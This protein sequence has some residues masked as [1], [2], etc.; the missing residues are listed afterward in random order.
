[1]ERGK[2][3]EIK[4]LSGKEE[5]K[6]EWVYRRVYTLFA[7]DFFATYNQEKC[8][9]FSFIPEADILPFDNV[10]RILEGYEKAYSDLRD[11]LNSIGKHRRHSGRDPISFLVNYPYKP[12]TF[13]IM[14]SNHKSKVI[15]YRALSETSINSLK[16]EPAFKDASFR[17]VDNLDEYISSEELNRLFSQLGLC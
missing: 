4:A 5:E 2:K 6:R 14:R 10:E 8:T 1:M 16:E 11:Y 13:E 9:M 3:D 7:V 12:S 17:W 15:V